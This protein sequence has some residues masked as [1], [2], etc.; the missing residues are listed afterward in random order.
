MIELT[1]PAI[2]QITPAAWKKLLDGCNKP[3]TFFGRIDRLA[4]QIAKVPEGNPNAFY[5]Q[6]GQKGS[7]KFKG[8]VFEIICG[9]GL[10]KVCRDDRINIYDYQVVSENDTGVDGFGITKDRFPTAVQ[11][12]YAPWDSNIIHTKKRLDNFDLTARNR[13]HVD[14]QIFPGRMLVITSA[15]Q[16]SWRTIARYG[17]SMR[18][19]SR[20][21]SYGC[22]KGA[23]HGKTVDNLFSLK[24]LLD[25]HLIF[26]DEVRKQVGV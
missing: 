17:G 6:S 1:H 12:K 15:K 3:G 22:L 21:A 7:S 8:D 2:H 26:W 13:Y 16:M 4:K 24:T 11:L 23:P 5:H 20:D 18:C 25:D 9:E 10:I 19:I 14:T